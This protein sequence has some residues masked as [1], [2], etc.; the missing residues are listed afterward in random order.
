VILLCIVPLCYEVSIAQ[1]PDYEYYSLGAEELLYEHYSTE[2]GLPSVEV[3]QSLQ[4]SD[5]YLWFV[6]D[7]GVSRFDGYSF[8][9]G[10][11]V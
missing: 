2:Q 11:K 5:G 6:T 10:K 9:L 3:Y 8:W 7:E 1:I 4:D